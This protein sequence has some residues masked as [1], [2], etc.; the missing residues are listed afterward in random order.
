MTDGPPLLDIG[1]GEVPVRGFEVHDGTELVG[2]FI[3]GDVGFISAATASNPQAVDEL[4]ESDDALTQ[5]EARDL[6]VE[7]YQG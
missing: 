1:T 2:Y 4:V 5:D 7:G 3:P 6:F